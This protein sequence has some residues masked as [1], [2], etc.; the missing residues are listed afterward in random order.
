VFELYGQASQGLLIETDD[1]GIAFDMGE[2]HVDSLAD[3]LSRRN[4]GGFSQGFESLDLGWCQ[5]N[6]CTYLFHQDYHAL[7]QADCQLI[8]SG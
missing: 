1:V 7:R 3:V 2:D 6:G 8:V 4:F 5:I